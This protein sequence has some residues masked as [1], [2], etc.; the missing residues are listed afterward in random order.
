MFMKDQRKLF[1]GFSL[2]FS[3]WCTSDLKNCGEKNFSLL[4][5]IDELCYPQK[6][7]WALKFLE[8]YGSPSVCMHKKSFSTP[9][10]LQNDFAEKIVNTVE[11]CLLASSN[12]FRCFVC[13]TNFPPLAGESSPFGSNTA[14]QTNFFTIY[15][16]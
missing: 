16:G 8:F 3:F 13:G 5:Q 15:L 7:A 10:R 2:I 11:V 1:A 9:C 14:T 4:P 6:T 12:F